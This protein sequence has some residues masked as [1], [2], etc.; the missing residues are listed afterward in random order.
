MSLIEDAKRLARSGF[1]PWEDSCHL[2]CEMC[3]EDG[4]GE[5]GPFPHSPNCP[6]L[7]MPRIVA[8]LEAAEALVKV[9]DRSSVHY[10]STITN[11]KTGEV[12]E[13]CQAYC[14][15]WPCGAAK[16]DAAADALR[17]ALAGGQ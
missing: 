4:A 8:A 3:G 5:D 17:D 14:A 6:W 13:T 1:T 15:T 9:I 16:V 11:V 12:I 10:P 7:A 2:T